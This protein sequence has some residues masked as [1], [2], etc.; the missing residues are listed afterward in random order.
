[1]LSTLSSFYDPSSL[2]SPFILRGRRILHDICQDTIWQNGISNIS[3]EMQMLEKWSTCV[4]ED[5]IE[6]HIKSGGFGEIIHIS[7]HSFPKESELG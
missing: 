5:W 7:L 6:K 2:A 1:M 4:R 3:K